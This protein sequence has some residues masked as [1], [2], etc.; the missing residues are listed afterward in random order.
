MLNSWKRRKLTLHGQI[1]IVKTLGL[2]KLIY[3]TSVLV[4]PE[5]YVKVCSFLACVES[6]SVELGSKE[7]PRNG[8]FGILLVRKMGR[9]PKKNGV[10]LC[11]R[12]AQK[13]LLRTLVLSR[14]QPQKIGRIVIS[15]KSGLTK[16]VIFI[17][18]KSSKETD[19]FAF[20]ESDRFSMT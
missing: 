11:S 18:F 15:E 20:L 6:V 16:V 2:S 9:E 10:I 14:K 4:I 5:H 19:I 7:R 17:T 13:R 3:N 8:V 12:T 1:K